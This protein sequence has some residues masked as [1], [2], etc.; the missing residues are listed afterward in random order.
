MA[1]AGETVVRIAARVGCSEWLIA[2][3]LRLLGI[4]TWR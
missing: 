4:E 2:K 1:R 3:R